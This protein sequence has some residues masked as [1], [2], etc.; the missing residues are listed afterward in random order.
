MTE[1]AFQS[2]LQLGAAIRNKSISAAEMLDYFL[3]RVE[4]FNPDLN[5]IVV[6]DFDR[7]REFAIKA[8]KALA[9]G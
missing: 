7:A 9:Q 1:L 2:A 4:K 8:D 5:A 3:A 6:E